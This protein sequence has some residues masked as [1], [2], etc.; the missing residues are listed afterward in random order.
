MSFYLFGTTKSISIVG[1]LSHCY[2]LMVFKVGK[3]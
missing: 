1:G 3:T 2:V